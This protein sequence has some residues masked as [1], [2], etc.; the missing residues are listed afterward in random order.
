M[1][2]RIAIG[3]TAGAVL[4][5]TG[6]GYTVFKHRGGPVTE[7][8][9]SP[10]GEAE[11]PV[12]RVKTVVLKNG[13]IDKT[14][15]V[16]GNVIPAP[17]AQTTVSVPFESRIRHLMVNEGQE[18]SQ[19]APLLELGPSP[20][21]HMKFKQAQEN[22]EVA[23]QALKNMERKFQLKLATNDQLLLARQTLEQ[24]QLTI[25][26]MRSQG[27]DGQ[28][29]LSAEVEG[30]VIKVLVD[31]GALVPAGAPLLQMVPRNRLESRLG[32]EP[33][34]VDSVHE[35][36]P[37]SLS[38]VQEQAVVVSGK[39]RKVSRSVNPATHLVDVFV[40]VPSPSEFLLG[41][42]VSGRIVVGSVK[43]VVV[44][45]NAV[46]PEEGNS[47]LFVVRSGRALKKNVRLLAENSREAV[48]EGEGLRPG[49]EVVIVGN[50]ELKDNMRI[51]GEPAR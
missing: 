8:P 51:V 40:S 16:Y 32:V 42:Y 7:Q 9:A 34:D 4:L 35:G 21:T 47:V 45:R 14:I 1:R 11:G 44:P 17:G 50:Y 25:D 39:V 18:V 41:Q 46:L 31:E 15:L 43:G 19:G 2:R 48:V 24:A 38:R 22:Y 30:L 23:G 20:E 13:S 27:I 37:V 49:D 10:A 6:I 36:M 26:S 12:A 5:L 29:E 33:E 3:L 28:R